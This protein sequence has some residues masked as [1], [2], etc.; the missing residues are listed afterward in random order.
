[1]KKFSHFGNLAW[2]LLTELFGIS[3]LKL[4]FHRK[5]AELIFGRTHFARNL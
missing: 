2:R 4:L 3:P 5:F 1:M